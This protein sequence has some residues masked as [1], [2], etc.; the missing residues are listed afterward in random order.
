MEY[1]YYFTIS[2]KTTSF[3][4]LV[5]GEN[6]LDAISTIPIFINKNMALLKI[7]RES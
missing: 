7:I 3:I 6:M 2:F 4:S 1:S 5:I